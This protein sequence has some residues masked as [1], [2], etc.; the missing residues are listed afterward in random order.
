MSYTQ[1]KWFVEESYSID[2]I[3][4]L[5]KFNVQRELGV[6]RG[7][8]HDD[9]KRIVDCVNACYGMENPADEI[10][11]LRSERDALLSS[12]KKLMSF[13]MHPSIEADETIPELVN[14]QKA[15]DLAG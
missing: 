7:A 5:G 2:A 3:A 11:K 4:M 14:M 12:S 6:K 13:I 10:A 1:G 9:A 15:I 8:S